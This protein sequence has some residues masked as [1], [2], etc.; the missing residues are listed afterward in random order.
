MKILITGGAGYIGTTLAP[1][2]A[3]HGNSVTVLDRFFF[4]QDQIQ[5]FSSLGIASIRD[6]TRYFDGRQLEGFDAVVDMAAL[7]NDPAGELDPWKTLEINYLGRSRVARLAKEAGV[8]SYLLISSCSVY[9]FQEGLLTESSPTKPLTTYAKAN[10]LAE[11]DNL[12][13]GDSNFTSTAA[14]LATIYGLSE[15]MRF[16]LAINMMVF[17]GVRNGKIPVMRDGKQWR[18][19]LHVKDAAR[20][21]EM[22]LR[23]PGE[24]VNRNIFNI[25][26]DAQ[27][28]QIQELAELVAGALS[29]RPEIGWYGTPDNRS[30]RV[31]FRKAREVLG[32]DTTF[33]PVDAARE[34]EKEVISNRLSDAP[35]TNTLQWYK[36]LLSDQRAAEEVALRGS[37]L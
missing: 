14:R 13:L 27:N 32:F 2:L 16:D 19:F 37:V 30:Y 15:R 31:S 29:A 33:T 23:S 9:G 5:K 8:A 10:L 20:A 7:S 6:D 34:I 1:F 24:K 17:G 28:Y 36:H 11:G 12:V 22:I 3:A 25:G 35:K 26:S 21:I 4:G 18:P